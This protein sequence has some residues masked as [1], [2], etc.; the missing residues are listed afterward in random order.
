[1]PLA[2]QI[3][4][5]LTFT[6]GSF[7]M[8]FFFKWMSCLFGLKFRIKIKKIFAWYVRHSSAR[9]CYQP[10]DTTQQARLWWMRF[11]IISILV[12]VWSDALCHV[13]SSQQKNKSHCNVSGR[14]KRVSHNSNIR[15]II[16]LVFSCLSIHSSPMTAISKWHFKQWKLQAFIS[17]YSFALLC[18]HQYYFQTL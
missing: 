8:I 9:L 16:F 3:F 11:L 13:H 6:H 10:R 1:M 15:S 4:I 5:Y 18:R 7:L 17:F 2:Y 12:S 14:T